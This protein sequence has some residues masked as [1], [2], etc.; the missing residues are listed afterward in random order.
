MIDSEYADA[1]DRAAIQD[2][3]RFRVVMR[4]PDELEN[5]CTLHVTGVP[6]LNRPEILTRSG[7]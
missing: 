4:V 1:L 3:E 6:A 5:R 7:F 2:L